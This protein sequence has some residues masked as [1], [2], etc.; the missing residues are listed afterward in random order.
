M[1]L[2]LV[3][4]PIGEHLMS[5]FEYELMQKVTMLMNIYSNMAA[6]AYHLGLVFPL[7]SFPLSLFLGMRLVAEVNMGQDGWITIIH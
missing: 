5:F 7:T 6:E 2:G 4:D 1:S 3:T